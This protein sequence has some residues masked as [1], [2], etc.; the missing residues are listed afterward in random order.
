MVKCGCLKGHGDMTVSGGGI[1]RIG[2][3]GWKSYQCYKWIWKKKTRLGKY[4]DHRSGGEVSSCDRKIRKHWWEEGGMWV[5]TGL[6]W[7]QTQYEKKVKAYTGDF[8]FFSGD[9]L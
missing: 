6:A 8:V 2:C 1:S 4:K 5:C 7:I 9:D 3:V